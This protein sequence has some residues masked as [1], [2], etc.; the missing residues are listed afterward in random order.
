MRLGFEPVEN[1]KNIGPT[2]AGHLRRIGI[3]TYADLQKATPAKAYLHLK[4][5]FPDRTWPVCYYLYSL[6]GALRDKHWDNL[7]K[8]VKEKLLREIGE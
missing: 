4:A 8:S 7:P 3:A 6:E 1:L 5:S 2:V